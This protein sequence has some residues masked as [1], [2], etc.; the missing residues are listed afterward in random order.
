MSKRTSIKPCT[1]E[2][3]ARQ[4]NSRVSSIAGKK[5]KKKNHIESNRMVACSSKGSVILVVAVV[6][7]T[8]LTLSAFVVR[9]P[10]AFVPSRLSSLSPVRCNISISIYHRCGKSFLE[11][12][13]TRILEGIS[14]IITCCKY[15][16]I[17]MNF[18]AE[19]SRYRR[20]FEN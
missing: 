18:D 5:R 7:G 14:I 13:P 17:H 15:H 20:V 1:A 19:K 12:A 8:K 6:A 10:A 16:R 4:V 9:S 3:T 11:D 2:H